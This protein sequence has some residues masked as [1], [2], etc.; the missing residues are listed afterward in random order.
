MCKDYSFDCWPYRPTFKFTISFECIFFY[1]WYLLLIGHVTQL[2]NPSDVS[3]WVTW[4]A[5]RTHIVCVCVV[6]VCVCL[7]VCV[8]VCVWCVVCVCVWCVVCVCLC[9]WVGG[10]VCVCVWCVYVC[11]CVCVRVSRVMLK[12]SG[13]VCGTCLNSLKFDGVSVTRCMFHSY[14]ISDTFSIGFL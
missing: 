9:V 4:N 14:K 2:I 5:V 12:M 1:A 11:V 3:L 6:C 7:C 13:V 10:C 8:C